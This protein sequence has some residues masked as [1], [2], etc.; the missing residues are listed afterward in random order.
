M[1]TTPGSPTPS[2]SATGAPAGTA[3]TVAAW[4]EEFTA[5]GVTTAICRF[6][7]LD[8]PGQVERFAAEVLPALRA[9]E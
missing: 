7:A 6:A 8:Q 3:G 1:P 2:T 5:A 4:L 9:T